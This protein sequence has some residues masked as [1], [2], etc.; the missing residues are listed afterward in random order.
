MSEITHKQ[1]EAGQAV[2]GKFTL[3]AYDS[4][5]LG[6]S[7]R[8]VWKC[9]ASFLLARYNEYV[10]GNHLDVGVGSGYFLDHCD[11]PVA[12]PRVALMDM[13]SHSL[14]FTAQR[15]ARYRPTTWQRNVLEDMSVEGGV[16]DSVGMNLLLH[17]VPGD[18][19]EKGR[20]FD[21]ARELMNPGALLFGATLLGRGVPRSPAARAL[22]ALYNRKGIFS[23]RGDSAEGLQ[24]ALAARFSDVTVATVGC[25]AL[26]SARR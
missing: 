18:F 8:W 17:C 26:F 15:I 3:S 20:I 22:M 6:A 21:N 9:P 11:F 7:C 1:V 12:H 23:N 19:S 24:A 16:F 10:S 2:Y 25:M 5:V 13:N 14:A 4:V